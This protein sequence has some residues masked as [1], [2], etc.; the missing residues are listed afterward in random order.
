MEILAKYNGNNA[1]EGY[2]PK[3]K[4]T[5]LKSLTEYDTAMAGAG[6]HNVVAICYHNLCPSA[7][8]AWDKMKESYSNI[9]LYKINTDKYAAGSSKA[10]KL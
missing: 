10:V 3:G 8:E 4:V 1:S 7:E 5:E 6:E 9:H 2:S